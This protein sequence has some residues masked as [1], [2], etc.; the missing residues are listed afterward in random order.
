MK[1]EKRFLKDDDQSKIMYFDEF[2]DI[3]PVISYMLY[4]NGNPHEGLY[5]EEIGRA[6]ALEDFKMSA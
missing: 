6:R 1:G 2:S 3:F 4:F 5:V